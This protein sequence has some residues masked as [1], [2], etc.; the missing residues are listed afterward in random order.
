MFSVAFLQKVVEFVLA[1]DS[2]SHSKHMRHYAVRIE[3]H[4]VARSLPEKTSASEEIVESVRTGRVDAE[5]GER[6]LEPSGLRV[7]R[8]EIGDDDQRI[9]L[10]GQHFRIGDHLIVVELEPPQRLVVLQNF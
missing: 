4:E 5:L 7:I 1:P 8:I 9:E 10:A 3:P 6:Q 2:P